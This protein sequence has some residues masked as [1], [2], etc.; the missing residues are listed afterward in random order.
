MKQNLGSTHRGRAKKRKSAHVAHELPGA[1][2]GA[3]AG[4]IVGALGGPGGSVTGAVLGGVAGAV[5]ERAIEIEQERESAHQRELDAAIGVSEG[6]L[7]A[8]NL[9]HPPAKIGAYSVAS[10]GGASGA[11]S[12][13]AEGPMVPPDKEA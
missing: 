13:P 2:G 7:G 10:S 9:K 1:A 11:G 3:V 12:A 6:E 5:A 8:P 4:A